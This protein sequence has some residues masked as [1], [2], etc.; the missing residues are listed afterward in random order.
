MYNVIKKNCISC[1]YR[2]ELCCPYFPTINECKHWKLGK[3]YTCKYYDDII[4][5]PDAW[6]GRGC[7]TWCNSGCTK[8]KRNWKET[9]KWYKF[10]KLNKK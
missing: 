5:N 1:L 7:E 9:F 10:L 6:Y 4:E 3:C 2:H 8:Y